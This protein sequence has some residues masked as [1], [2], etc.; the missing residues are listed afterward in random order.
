GVGTAFQS[1]SGLVVLGSCPG[2]RHIDLDVSG[3]TGINGVPVL[4][5]NVAALLQVGMLSGVLHVLD[6]VF[7]G[8][9]LG[10]GEEGG[11]QDGVGTLAH[12]HL[13]GQVDS[14]DG[15]QLNVVVGNVA[16][17]S[18]IQVML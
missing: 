18:S 6:G 13:D 15:V 17:G 2:S 11:L 3:S 1:G 10:Q 7:R 9:N 5:H 12:A 16:L 4:L 8:H 14:V